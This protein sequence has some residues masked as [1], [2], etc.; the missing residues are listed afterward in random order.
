MK[1]HN[2]KAIIIIAN[3]IIASISITSIYTVASG[4]FNVI[5][6]EQD[7]IDWEVRDGKLVFTTNV[8][9]QN[10]GFYSIKGLKINVD[11]LENSTGFKLIEYQHTVDII[12]MRTDHIEQLEIP[13]DLDR[14]QQLYA[15]LDNFI[16][17]DWLDEV[18]KFM[19]NDTAL[20]LIIS[21]EA[22]YTMKLVRFNADYTFDF[23]WPATIQ[24]YDIDTS[25]ITQY[26]NGP[27]IDLELPFTLHTSQWITGDIRVDTHLQNS[28]MN[29][30]NSITIIPL[31]Q[32]YSGNLSIHLNPQEMANLKINTQALYLVVMISTSDLGIIYRD[33]VEFAADIE[34][35]QP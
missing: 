18:D 5:L 8:T 20:S 2:L 19:F 13:L 27:G 22:Y 11:L 4:N 24:I 31:G 23:L 1:L 3:I 21:V 25:N 10:N 35:E 32:N 12:P 33:M 14:Y 15:E 7:D 28:T 30:A 26:N 6:P 16:P 29:F 17:E 34:L 9:I